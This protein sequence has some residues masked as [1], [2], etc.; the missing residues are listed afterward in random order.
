MIRRKP[1]CYSMKSDF[2]RLT[3]NSSWKTNQRNIERKI[4]I[5]GTTMHKKM[6]RSCE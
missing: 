1:G 2:S 3:L 5:R 4:K 6:V